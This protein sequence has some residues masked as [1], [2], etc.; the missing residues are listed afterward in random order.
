M[1][2][3]Y[4]ELY[5][6]YLNGEEKKLQILIEK[7]GPNLIFFIN[8]YVH[9]ITI[10]EDLMEETFTDLIYYKNRF[11]GKSLFK[12]YLFSIARNKTFD[13]MKKKSKL[14]WISLYELDKMSSDFLDLEKMIIK[15]EQQQ[16]LYKALNQISDECRGALYL[17]YY[18]KMSYEEI[19][20]VMKKNNKQI[21]N[22][23]YRS[24]KKL[25]DIMEKE[26]FEY[27]E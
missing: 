23:M 11:K 12:T 16:Q 5:F 24:K 20:I 18:E 4:A 19:A 22:I 10:A 2:D 6:Q 17:F 1:E 7:L 13:F 26:G 25:K 14:K 27:E 3:I 8:S 21:K 15:N 9:N